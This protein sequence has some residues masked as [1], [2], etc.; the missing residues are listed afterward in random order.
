M[1]NNPSQTPQWNPN[2]PPPTSQA[3]AQVQG[4]WSP[5]PPN[6]Q[7]YAPRPN[8]VSCTCCC[9]SG[10]CVATP[11]LVTISFVTQS[12]FK[13]ELAPCFQF[14]ATSHT[15]RHT[16]SQWAQSTQRL[17]PTVLTRTLQIRS[18]QSRKPFLKAPP[19]RPSNLNIRTST[20]RCQHR[21]RCTHHP[22][23][24]NRW[25]TLRTNQ[26]LDRGLRSH[27]D[28]VEDARY[29]TMGQYNSDAQC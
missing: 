29:A 6:G 2:A 20:A 9:S 21:R 17:P 24:R 5:Q 26:H 14:S 4:Q 22:T 19:C 27:A 1:Y 25:A 13:L 10:I 18:L 11:R 28:I 3:Q 16:P 7:P 15:Q 8:Q 12:L 23:S